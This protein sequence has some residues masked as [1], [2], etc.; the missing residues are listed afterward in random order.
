MNK[1][2]TSVIAYLSWIGWLIAYLAGDKEGAK[3]H[4]NQAGVLAIVGLA[5]TVL[6]WVPIVGRFMW[7]VSTVVGIFSLV[8]L[9]YAAQDQDKHLPLIGGITLLK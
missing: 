4:L 6:A 8:G 1:K 3:F 7:I 9:I 5:T 2:A